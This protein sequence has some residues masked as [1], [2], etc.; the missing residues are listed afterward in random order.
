MSSIEDLEQYYGEEVVSQA[1]ALQEHI[2]Q[3]GIDG[4]WTCWRW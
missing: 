1:F 2:R 3:N 4:I